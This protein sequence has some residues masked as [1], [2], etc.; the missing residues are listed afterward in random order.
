MQAV[1]IGIVF[2]AFLGLIASALRGAWDREQQWK[3]DEAAWAAAHPENQPTGP[4]SIRWVQLLG[5]LGTLALLA[6]LMAAGLNVTQACVVA[7][8][9]VVIARYLTRRR[10]EREPNNREQFGEYTPSFRDRR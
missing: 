9:P 2:V 6:A 5:G 4:P 8:V 7:A 10:R 3:A 1:L